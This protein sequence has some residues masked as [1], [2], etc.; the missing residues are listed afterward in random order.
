MSA[1]QQTPRRIA[2]LF[3]T[4]PKTS[5]TFYQREVRA[6]L[7][8]GLEL[9]L[10]SL[11]R[12]GGSF[13]G[14]PVTRFSKW[15][16]LTLL[17]R[18]PQCALAHPRPVLKNLR[19]LC[20]KP[21]RWLNF[22]ENLLGFGFAV[23]RHREFAKHPPAA[24]H[25]AWTTAPGAAGWLLSEITGRPFS[26]GAHAYDVFQAGGDWFLREKLEAARFVVTSNKAALYRIQEL[27]TDAGKVHL[28]R[29]GLLPFPTFE[30]KRPT[31]GEPLHIL[32]V[33]RLL[34]KKGYPAQ[35]QIY[36]ELKEAGIPFIAEI[37]GGGSLESTLRREIQRLGLQDHVT[38]A[39]AL[40][41]EETEAHY[42]QAHV[43]LF[44][45][46]EAAD[47]DRDGLPN[48]IPEAMAHGLL[49]LASPVADVPTAMQEGQTGFLLDPEQPAEW[50]KKLQTFYENP[51]AFQPIHQEARAWTETHFD[52]VKNA[53]QLL[54]LLRDGNQ[55]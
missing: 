19:R 23:V 24:F 2:Y 7:S 33:G 32:S 22:W 35:L 31:S 42:K 47:G 45:G 52:A 29:R 6:L 37:I 10:H 12:G 27:G 17:W 13:D 14:H 53:Q 50:L 15:A 51:D 25:C 38:L 48:V 18:L 26:T 55:A 5:E 34:P 54:E 11:H 43:F 40:D 28:V 8:L 30:P 3:T 44:T 36:R 21:P 39:G 9:E 20:S 1:S 41:Y 16:L 4:F 46:K 49:V